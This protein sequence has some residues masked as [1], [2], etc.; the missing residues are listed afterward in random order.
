MKLLISGKFGC[1]FSLLLSSTYG[2]YISLK[3]QGMNI[4]N[5]DQN[6]KKDC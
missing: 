4:E 5:R 6:Y 3:I 1:G 2:L